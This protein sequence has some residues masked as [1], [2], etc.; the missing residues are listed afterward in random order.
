M[1]MPDVYAVEPRKDAAWSYQRVW[2]YP[3]E[4]C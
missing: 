4:S 3:A 2:S 1:S